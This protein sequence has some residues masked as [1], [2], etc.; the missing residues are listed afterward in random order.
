MPAGG[1]RAATNAIEVSLGDSKV[2][3]STRLGS[4]GGVQPGRLSG[5][6]CV[7]NEGPSAAALSS[8]SPFTPTHL[9]TDH[10]I[11]H[12]GPL[13]YPWAVALPLDPPFSEAA[14]QSARVGRSRERF[15]ARSRW[16]RGR[17]EPTGRVQRRREV[18]GRV[19]NSGCCGRSV[20]RVRASRHLDSRGLS[21]QVGPN[22]RALSPIF[23]G[24]TRLFLLHIP[25]IIKMPPFAPA[26]RI[27]SA[28]TLWASNSSRRAF[29]SSPRSEKQKLVIVGSGWAGTSELSLAS[30][31]VAG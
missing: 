5:R 10:L 17:G 22:A 25:H 7:V 29:S 14:F 23:W 28:S 20:T 2:H 4:G 26:L 3:N 31:D 18:Y 13:S 8:R 9:L 27:K 24:T 21:G 6:A 11:S 30:R 12:I 19:M 15:R 16:R 1:A